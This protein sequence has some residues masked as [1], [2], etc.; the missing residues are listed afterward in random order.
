MTTPSSPRVPLSPVKL[1]TASP[2]SLAAPKMTGV[3]VNIRYYWK[4]C[5]AA[6]VFLGLLYLY[7]KNKCKGN[8][9]STFATLKNFLNKQ[10]S[11]NTAQVTPSSVKDSQKKDI[12]PPVVINKTTPSDPNFT[13]LS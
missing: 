8:S 4:Y 10:S 9:R 5:L 1:P 3:L 7:M 12:S 6:M 13:R 11:G 2:A